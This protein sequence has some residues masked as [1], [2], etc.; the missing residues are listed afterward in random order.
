V[1]EAVLRQGGFV[2]DEICGYGVLAGIE[3]YLR[4]A[5]GEVGRREGR[6]MDGSR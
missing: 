2:S 4:A 3:Y 6:E 5:A 1:K